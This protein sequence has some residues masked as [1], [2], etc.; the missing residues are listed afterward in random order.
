MKILNQLGRTQFKAWVISL[1]Q[2]PS[3]Q[4]PVSLLDDL[5]SS[6]S[7]NIEI[8]LPPGPFTDKYDFAVAM[9]DIAK[10]IEATEVDYE[11]WPSIWDSLALH[12]FSEVCPKTRSGDWDPNK[13]HHYCYDPDYK[14]RHRHRIYGPLTLVRN[15]GD[16]VAPFF[17]VSPSTL[18][19]FEEQVGSRQEL[20]GNLTA[21]RVIRSFFANPEG[22]SQKR[23][24]VSR[25]VY[26]GF[27]KKLPTPGN[28]L[29][30]TTVCKQLRRTYDLAGVSEEGFL[31]VLPPEF[32]KGLKR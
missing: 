13:H 17:H 2:N 27:K 7:I 11:F 15:G 8:M 4:P 28:L 30:F 23:G 3:S 29:R 20:A 12:Y 22:T 6:V 1:E 25:K 18:G 14:V 26:E 9:L 31:D 32:T 5:A 10:A 24:F 21:L 16:A 19:D